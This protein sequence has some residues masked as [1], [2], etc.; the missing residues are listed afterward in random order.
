MGI[1]K[2]V[3][4][5]TIQMLPTETVFKKHVRMR[6]KFWTLLVNVKHAPNTLILIPVTLTVL[7][8]L[9]PVI[10]SYRSQ[11]LVQIVDLTHTPK[12]TKRSALLTTAL[13]LNNKNTF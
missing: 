5:F 11:E 4:L 3:I 10:K 7:L 8:M 2:V 13:T 12:L 6:L 9:V 1:A